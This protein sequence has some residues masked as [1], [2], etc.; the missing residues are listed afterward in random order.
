[1]P[2]VYQQ[3]INEGTRIGVW[4]IT[5]DE[6]FFLKTV[7]AQKEIRHPH[8]RLQ[9]LAGRYLLT[10]LHPEFP[11]D[12]I[13]V[14]ASGRPYLENGQQNF[15]ISHSDNYAAVIISDN[16]RVGIDIELQYHGII[17]IKNKFTSDD[18]LG[19]FRNEDH[20]TV[21]KLT[22]IW[23]IK[24]AM[25]KWYGTGSLD[26]KKHLRIEDVSLEQNRIAAICTI[27]KNSI[28]SLSSKSML[29]G[30]FVLTWVM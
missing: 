4:H 12:L 17:N 19:K 5:E 28:T 27:H 21:Q 2:L 29:I 24:E 1:M 13:L 14:D 26:F 30:E 16:A 3:D 7:S 11:V 23:S 22:F 10:I 20:S 25:Y 15:S 6:S 18:E 8:K 9:H